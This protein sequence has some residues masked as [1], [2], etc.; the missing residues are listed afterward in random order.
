MDAPSARSP[1]N[2]TADAIP[3]RAETPDDLVDVLVLIDENFFCGLPVLALNCSFS[4]RCFSVNA[5][6][7]KDR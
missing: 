6:C 7:F 2:V 4:R 1:P 3:P 5:F